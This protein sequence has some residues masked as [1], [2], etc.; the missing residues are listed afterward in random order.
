VKVT[1]QLVFDPLPE[2]EQLAEE[3]VPVPLLENVTVPVGV[4]G[5]PG[6]LSVTVTVQVLGVFRANG[7]EQERATEM[8]R[9][10]TLSV[11]WAELGA[12][13]ASPP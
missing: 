10:M 3:K 6:L 4:I 2:S 13:V 5:V 7:L 8:P 12:W 9:L 1:L 11:L